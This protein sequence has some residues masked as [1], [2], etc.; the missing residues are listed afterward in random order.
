[1]HVGPPR[2]GATLLI[3]SL[4]GKGSIKMCTSGKEWGRHVKKQGEN[5]KNRFWLVTC[6]LSCDH[7][8]LGIAQPCGQ[9]SGYLAY[10]LQLK[11][12]HLSL[13]VMKALAQGSP[14]TPDL[15]YQA[16]QFAKRDS[17]L[18][19][20]T[21]PCQLHQLVPVVRKAWVLPVMHEGGEAINEFR[22]QVYARVRGAVRVWGGLVW[23]VST[24]IATHQHIL[25]ARALRPLIQ[26]MMCGA[27][28]AWVQAQHQVGMR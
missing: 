13:A 10:S 22:V 9:F 28:T 4:P 16:T 17:S 11:A 19:A 8:R 6:G 14:S 7:P 18:L 24:G 1:M 3:G 20:A 23:G 5:K 21:Q 27:G 15:A 25:R 12:L 26:G 2:C